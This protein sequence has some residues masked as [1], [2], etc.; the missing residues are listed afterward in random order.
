MALAAKPVADTEDVT[1]LAAEKLF[2]YLEFVLGQGRTRRCTGK[3][4]PKC[5]QLLCTRR[6]SSSVSWLEFGSTRVKSS[7]LIAAIFGK[8]SVRSSVSFTGCAGD[9]GMQRSC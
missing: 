5:C 3:R 2:F 1:D 8:S 9:G 6:E 4:H 7:G